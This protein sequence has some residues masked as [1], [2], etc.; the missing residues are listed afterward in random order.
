MFSRTAVI[1]L[2]LGLTAC[3]RSVP[4]SAPPPVAPMLQ[5]PV[6]SRTQSVEFIAPT[7]EE[8]PSLA[9]PSAA[10]KWDKAMT[11]KADFNADGLPDEALIGYVD[12]GLLLAIDSGRPDSTKVRTLMPFGVGQSQDSICSLP[13]TLRVE[14]ASCSVEGDELPGCRGADTPSGLVLGDR[15]GNCDS[16][17]LYWDH[18]KDRMNWWRN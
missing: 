16:I 4:P 17:H 3:S 12:D 9:D 11:V 15:D 5:E 8:G 7:T 1:A 2:V 18:Q 13:A 6:E 14:V 10:A